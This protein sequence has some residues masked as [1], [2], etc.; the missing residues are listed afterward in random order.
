MYIY[1][2][3]IHRWSAGSRPSGSMTLK[4]GGTQVQF[5]LPESLIGVI[6]QLAANAYAES[7]KE[8]L[9]AALLTTPLTYAQEQA[10]KA[11]AA[12]VIE[13]AQIEPIPGPFTTKDDEVAF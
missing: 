7:L 11:L 12:P 2:V 4:D 13:D 8:K 9:S 1:S 6:E 3:S 5:D 10:A